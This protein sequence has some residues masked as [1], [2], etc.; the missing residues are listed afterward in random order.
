[1]RRVTTTG[2][3]RRI[4]AQSTFGARAHDLIAL[5]C[6]HPDCCAIGYFLRDK[7]G[8]FS[9]LASI[10]GETSLRRNLSVFGNS[11][12]FLDGLAEIREALTNVMSES[13]TLSRPELVANLAKICTA[14][15]LGGFGQLLALAFRPGAS[16][17]FVGERIKRV[18]IKHFM[19]ADTLVTERLEQCCVHV[20]GAGNDPVRMPFCAARL[21]PKVRARAQAAMV[22][23]A[24]L[25]DGR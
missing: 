1:M 21:F 12:A 3:L 8:G 23:R 19:D 10:V 4:E 15:D 5:P 22:P 11:I 18:T 9:S 2:V 24:A 25:P 6:S 7:N 14:C 13:M 20:A 16:A 17:A